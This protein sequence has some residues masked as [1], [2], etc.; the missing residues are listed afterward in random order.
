M[1]I[2]IDLCCNVGELTYTKTVDWN[3]GRAGMYLAH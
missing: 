2:S 1:S 3:N